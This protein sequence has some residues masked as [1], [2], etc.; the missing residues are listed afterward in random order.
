M[1]TLKL[2]NVYILYSSRFYSTFFI[3]NQPPEN[4]KLLVNRR[5]HGLLL[6]RAERVEKNKGKHLIFKCLP[7]ISLIFSIQGLFLLQQL[8]PLISPSHYEGLLKNL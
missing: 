3:V 8:G 5:H 7:R 1:D 2:V 6:L 4:C